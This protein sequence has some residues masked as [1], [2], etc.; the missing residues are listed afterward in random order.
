MPSPRRRPSVALV[1]WLLAGLAL[2]VVPVAAQSLRGSKASM[3]RQNRVARQHDFSFLDTAS[4]VR[5]FVEAGY[6][7]PVR[8]GRHH[9]LHS[10]SFPYARPE[11][12]LFIERLAAQYHAACGE[13][14]VV[15]SL[16]RPRALQPP[17][18]SRRS[19]HPTG[20]ALDLRRSNSP[21]CHG[22]LEPVL[23]AL[24][25]SEVIEATREHHPPHYHIAV[26]PRQ[27]EAYVAAK[28][29]GAGDFE[30]AERVAEAASYLVRRGDTLWSIA[31]RHGTSVSAIRASNGLRS[32]YIRAGQVLRLPQ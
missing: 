12:K 15:T 30:V 26:Y 16:T 2:A 23:L 18:A 31:Q 29:D 22:W 14:L 19:V 10:V 4:G 1:C 13:K 3:D 20:M 25:E 27:Y 32:T 21:R 7:V 11:V 28:G 24:E 17:N 8:D 9:E 6:L 5:R